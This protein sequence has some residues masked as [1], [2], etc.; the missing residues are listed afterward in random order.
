MCIR[1]RRER[2]RERE[3]KGEHST[4]LRINTMLLEKQVEIAPWKERYKSRYCA[5]VWIFAACSE[6]DQCRQRAW[7]LCSPQTVSYTHLDVYK[8][9]DSVNDFE[10]TPHWYFLMPECINLCFAKL[11]DWVMILNKHHTGTY[12]QN[13]LTC[14]DKVLESV[15]FWTNITLVFLLPVC[16]VVTN[17]LTE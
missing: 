7:Q 6:C 9:Q 5:E 15:W 2:E 17:R 14:F 3:T 11:P 12:C 10:Q 4:S 13:V 16:I 1:D 8:R